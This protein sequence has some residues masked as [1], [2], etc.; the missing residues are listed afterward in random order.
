MRSIDSLTAGLL[1]LAAVAA[2]PLGW[3]E[4]TASGPSGF[5]LK[6]EVTVAGTPA[7]AFNRLTQIGRWWSPEHSY[8]G[9]AANLALSAQ[10]GGCFCETL[11]GGGFVKHMDVV[12]AAPGK[13]LRL[14]G[15]LGPLQGMGATG[16]LTFELKA[17][18]PNTRIGPAMGDKDAAALA[19]AVDGVLNEQLTRFKRF[20]ETG[21]PGGER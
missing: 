10:P 2:S 14:V 16:A 15:G 20:A 4:V 19:G 1:G 7:D 12:Y 18:G 9:E 17:D 21:K 8:S 13:T 6:T 11:P 3:A 5:S